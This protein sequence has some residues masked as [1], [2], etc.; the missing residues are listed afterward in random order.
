MYTVSEE[1]VSHYHR[2]G[3]IVLRRI[4]P[5]SLVNDLRRQAAI[6][7][8][9]ARDARGGQVQRLQ[10]VG[11]YPE[12]LDLAVFRDYYEL[13]DL[14]EAISTVLTPEHR[15]PGLDVLGILFEPRD[16]PY[17]TAWH[18]DITRKSSRMSLAD[19]RELMTDYR[20]ANQVNCA[21]YDD[22]CTWYVPGSHHRVYDLP[23]ETAAAGHSID[24]AGLDDATHEALGIAYCQRMPGA[25]QLHL[26]AG[27]FALYR[28]AGWHLGN[29]TPTARRATLHDALLTPAVERWWR[30]WIAGGDAPWHGFDDE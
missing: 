24:S 13:A 6:A 5:S 23:G 15:S 30:A 14:R 27:D 7:R 2:D 25:V 28:P 22:S 17:C 10:P 1:A 20:A 19:Y 18:R 29:Y 4:I 12:Q 3:Y 16:A 8:E 9:I 26:N 11:A 21:L